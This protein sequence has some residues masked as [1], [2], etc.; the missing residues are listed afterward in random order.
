MTRAAMSTLIPPVAEIPREL[1][2]R[3]TIFLKFAAP[4]ISWFGVISEDPA[5]FWMALV[6]SV[7]ATV[8][9]GRLKRVRVWGGKLLVS[10]YFSEIAVPLQEVESVSGYVGQDMIV[11]RFRMPTS[12]GRK[13]RFLGPVLRFHPWTWH[14]AVSE[15]QN[16]IWLATPR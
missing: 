12:F 15:L 7:V 11:V 8:V 14:P 9:L 1:S 16:L 2:S 13:I 5:M 10:N 4:T 6:C 3:G